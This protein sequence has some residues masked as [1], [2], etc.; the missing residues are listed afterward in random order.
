[1]TKNCSYFTST[2]ETVFGII[3]ESFAPI[4]PML[5][6]LL[7]VSQN[8]F[9]GYGINYMMVWEVCSVLNCSSYGKNKIK[10]H[11]TKFLG[12]LQKESYIL[13]LVTKGINAAW[14]KIC[15][16]RCKGVL[17]FLGHSCSFLLVKRLVHYLH[18]QVEP[19]LYDHTTQIV[20]RIMK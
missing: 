1:M 9:S 17:Q 12:S 2:K 18:N 19:L 15:C 3:I 10:N 4:A 8:K 5:M 20:G 11:L 13:I 16:C 7:L 6:W 14:T